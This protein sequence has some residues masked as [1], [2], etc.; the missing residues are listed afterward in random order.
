M[1]KD[2]MKALEQ[3]DTKLAGVVFTLDDDVDH[4]SFLLLRMLRSVNL[5]EQVGLD[6]IDCLDYQTVIERIEHVA[7][8][9]VDV[10]NS[11]I[12]LHGEQFPKFLL[13][14]ILEASREAC[15]IF[16]E[17]IKAFFI[18]DL[19]SANKIIGLKD[20]VKKINREIIEMTLKEKRASIVCTTCLIRDSIRRIADCGVDIAIVT[21]NRV[22]GRG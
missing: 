14:P 22:I 18:K 19:L 9:A 4:F 1:F 12:S 20:K 17:A 13:E 16:E 8:Y 3:Q 5:A 10:A 6:H 11:V 7:D 21:I 2:A 15:G